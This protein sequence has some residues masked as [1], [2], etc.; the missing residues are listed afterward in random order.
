MPE[1]DPIFAGKSYSP[2]K[3][4]DLDEVLNYLDAFPDDDQR[5]FDL[6]RDGIEDEVDEEDNRFVANHDAYLWPNIEE[7]ITPLT[8]QLG[9]DTDG[10]G[11]ENPLDDDDDGDGIVDD[12]DLDPADNSVPPP[13]LGGRVTGDNV[14][15]SEIIT[16]LA[17]SIDQSRVGT[18]R[19]YDPARRRPAES[20]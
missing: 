9:L 3:D 15:G 8:S 1:Q 5:A 19:S 20:G 10:D 13:A 18:T 11:I 12:L 6:D 2:F 16:S 17:S 4:D 14:N 7:V